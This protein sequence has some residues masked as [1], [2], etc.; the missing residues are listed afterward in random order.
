[1]KSTFLTFLLAFTIFSIVFTVAA[2]GNDSQLQNMHK[3]TNPN[4][5]YD[6]ETLKYFDIRENGYIDEIYRVEGGKVVE[7]ISV[8]EFIL[9]E[10]NEKNEF[11]YAQ[12]SFPTISPLAV[13]WSHIY[14]EFSN[15]ETRIFG[16]RASIIQENPGPGSDTFTLSYEYTETFSTSTSL[17][18]LQLRS[19]EN[20]VSYTFSNSRSINS[21]HTMTIEPG[22]SGYWRFDPKVRK[23]IGKIRN[24]LHG[25][26][27]SET[28][29]TTMYPT[30][31]NGQLD[32]WLV[33]VKTKL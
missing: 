28:S 3:T 22:Y 33:A 23:S 2:S 25:Q 6:T 4:I 20:G 29:V 15:Y 7:S 32:G 5:F 16:K 21:S 30:H 19:I 10:E 18:H 24:L 13:T 31:V 1:M 11:Q 12:D 27:I 14:N 8:E 9:M 26:F 17:T